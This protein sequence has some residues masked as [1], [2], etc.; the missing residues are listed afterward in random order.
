MPSTPCN[1]NCTWTTQS[2]LASCTSR[3]GG[4]ESQQTVTAT[5]LPRLSGAANKVSKAAATDSVAARSKEYNI[6]QPCTHRL[7]VYHK[8]VCTRLSKCQCASMRLAS[9]ACVCEV[10]SLRS[11]SA[12][13]NSPTRWRDF[14]LL[15][16]RIKTVEHIHR[17][18]PS[19]AHMTQ[20]KQ[21]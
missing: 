4:Q 2:L 19:R 8:P 15:D 1:D 9:P 18:T 13:S 12:P 16:N 21:C 3:C 11:A 14:T 10:S 5:S 17:E 20:F 7:F 6:I